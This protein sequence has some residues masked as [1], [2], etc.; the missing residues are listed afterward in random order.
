MGKNNLVADALRV[1]YAVDF[2]PA[3]SAP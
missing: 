2:G 3:G 1:A